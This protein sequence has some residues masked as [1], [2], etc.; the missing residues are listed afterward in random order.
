VV[1]LATAPRL[2][3]RGTVPAAHATHNVGPPPVALGPGQ[4]PVRLTLAQQHIDAPVVPVG[5]LPGGGLEVPDDPAVLG[6]WRD[7]ARPGAG[8]GT[9]VIDGHVDTRRQGPG[10]LYRLRDMPLGALVELTGAAGAQR[11]VVRAVH[12]YPKA[13]LPPDLFDRT[14]RPRLILISCGGSFDNA[15]RQYADNI[16]VYA[17]PAGTGG[18]PPTAGSANGLPLR[19]RSYSGFAGPVRRAGY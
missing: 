17:V 10:A 8:R 11:Y 15:T 9:V 4:E 13:A 16:V 1:R 3:Q 6:W 19:Y 2:P 12:S 18:S 5:V 7:G 14:G